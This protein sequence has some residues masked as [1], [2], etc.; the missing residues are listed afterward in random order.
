MAI[1]LVCGKTIELPASR[2]MPRAT[3]SA[4]TSWRSGEYITVKF[5]KDFDQA[6][7]VHTGG[8]AFPD[9]EASDEKGRWVAIGDVVMTSRQLAD[10]RALPGAFTQIANAIVPSGCIA[11]IGIAARLL[12]GSG[13]G[14]QAEFVSGPPF[15]F[16]AIANKFWH[17]RGGLA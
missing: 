4:K 6:I 17:T 14:L 2:I 16:I 5:L 7:R 15:R 10:S 12:A 8:R 3:T 11:N 13:G 9:R 1:F